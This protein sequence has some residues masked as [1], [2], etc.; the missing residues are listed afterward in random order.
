MFFNQMNFPTRSRLQTG[1]FG[2]EPLAHWNGQYSLM[3]NG[4]LIM[5]N[6]FNS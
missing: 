2:S 1:C 5:D 3:D 4:Q 6:V